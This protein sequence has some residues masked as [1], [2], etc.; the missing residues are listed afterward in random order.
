M[1]PRNPTEK[2]YEE[3]AAGLKAG[4]RADEIVFTPGPNKRPRNNEES[5]MQQALIKWWRLAHHKFRVPERL[6]FAIPNGMRK[7]AIIGAI[8]KRE[9]VRAGVP[10]LL[11]AYAKTKSIPTV[12]WPN[13]R[14]TVSHAGCF[15][16][17]KTKIGIVSGE[18]EEYH[19]CLSNAGYAVHVCRSTEEAIKAIE[20]YLQ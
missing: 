19:F 15:I 1:L 2:N 20:T 4:K 12:A 3:L 8:L 7:G 11:L 13:I 17:L 9:G 10:D 6:L 18:Q 5:R 14:E 16:E